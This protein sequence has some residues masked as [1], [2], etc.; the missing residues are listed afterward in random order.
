MQ[1]A[2]D[3]CLHRTLA[4]IGTRHDTEWGVGGKASPSTLRALRPGVL[5]AASRTKSTAGRSKLKKENKKKKKYVRG[6][7][8]G[9]EEEG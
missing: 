5:Y 7:R 3:E 8:E 2:R 4:I 1:A 6:E 9:E